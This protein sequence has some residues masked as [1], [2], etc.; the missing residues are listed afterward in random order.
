MIQS[1]AG[2]GITFPIN[3][4]LNFNVTDQGATSNNGVGMSFGSDDGGTSTNTDGGGFAFTVGQGNGTGVIGSHQ[5]IGTSDT[6][7]SLSSTLSEI[8]HT[9]EPSV[10]NGQQFIGQNIL[11]DH[12]NASNLTN[13]TG[14]LVGQTI[15]VQSD[16]TGGV[17]IGTN[18]YATLTAAGAKTIT[19]HQFLDLVPNIDTATTVTDLIG[20]NLETEAGSGAATNYFGLD[21]ASDWKVGTGLNV[22]SAGNQRVMP[23]KGVQTTTLGVAATTF[24]VTED[25][26]TLTGD[27]GGNTI[28]TITGGYAGQ[29]ITIIFTDGNV[30]ITDD[31]THAANS[32]DLSAAFTGA[33]DTTLKL[34]FDGTSWYEISRSVN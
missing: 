17:S 3:T 5:I 15:N 23:I 18:L 4:Q 6:N 30:T 24:A 20:I 22:R 2:N 19:R 10:T 8:T 11:V 14:A 27:G 32:V 31:N 34:V 7:P 33:D 26:I 12:G 29:E 25:V 28:A 9:V 1:L 13:S 16:G 21:I